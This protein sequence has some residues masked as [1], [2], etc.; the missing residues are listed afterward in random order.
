MLEARAERTAEVEYRDT[1]ATIAPCAKSAN[2]NDN[3][4]SSAD[5]KAGTNLGYDFRS[6]NLNWFFKA[7]TKK[8]IFLQLV[9]FGRIARNH[10]G[11]HLFELLEAADLLLTSLSVA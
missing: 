10:A 4:I 9:G 7:N 2:Q 8:Y 11:E 5:S 6:K 1:G 3:N